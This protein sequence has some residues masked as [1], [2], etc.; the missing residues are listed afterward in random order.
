MAASKNY[1]NYLFRNILRMQE[2]K[3]HGKHNKRQIKQNWLKELESQNKAA[4]T[5]GTPNR[6]EQE[7][8]AGKVI[9][10]KINDLNSTLHFLCISLHPRNCWGEGGKKK[11][12][13]HITAAV[14]REHTSAYC[15]SAA[16]CKWADKMINTGRTEASLIFEEMRCSN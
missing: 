12:I 8:W 9:K 5:G 1:H 16:E 2:K 11:N 7:L 3:N 15:T 13:T 4:P 10:K 6:G 14:R